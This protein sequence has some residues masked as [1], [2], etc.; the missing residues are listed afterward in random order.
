MHAITTR[1]L[2]RH[3]AVAVCAATALGISSAADGVMISYFANLNGPSEAPPNVSPGIG[4][5]Q[6][7]IDTVAHTMRVQATF[8]GLLANTTAAHIHAATAV[9]FTGTAGV[10]TQ[11]PS[12]VGFPLGVTSGVFDNTL[13]TLAA[14]TYNPAYVTAN[15]GTPES[16]EAALFASLAAGTAYFNIHSTMFPAGEI[17]GFLL[18]PAPSA[19]AMFGLLAFGT[20]R[21][22][23]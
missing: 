7:D 15:G 1:S 8:S 17:R 20:R 6:V 9:P 21:R 13:N 10:A 16:A 19:L 18:V 14:S 2:G 4:F 12:F 5:A 23:C 11:T 22:R 3:L